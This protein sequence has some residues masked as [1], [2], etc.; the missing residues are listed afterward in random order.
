MNRF[1]YPSEPSGPPGPPRKVR[2][3]ERQNVRASQS[4]LPDVTSL[5]V[6]TR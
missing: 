3:P 6:R 5:Y 2:T 1:P 4:A